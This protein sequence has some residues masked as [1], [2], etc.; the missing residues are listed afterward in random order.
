MATDARLDREREFHDRAFSE[1][2]R[3]TVRRF[4][5]VTDSLRAWYDATLAHEAQDG[6]VLEYGCG[7]GSASYHLARQGA[8]VTGIDI[9]PV[10]IEM[11]REQGERDGLSANLDFRVMD[12]ERLDLPD[13][14]FDVVCGTGIL[15]HLDLDAAY[16]EV[17]RVLRPGG[18]AV[19]VEPLGHNPAINLYRSRTPGLRTVD[20]HPLLMADLDRC[21]DFFGAVDTRF[22][23]LTS[24][25]AFP[26]RRRARFEDVVRGLDRLDQVLFSTLPAARRNAWM[27]GMVLRAP[28]PR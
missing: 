26:L 20:E 2:T 5:S 3:A 22:F 27:V 11:A 12:A 28:R 17:A 16:G 23:A 7:P 1:S 6:T 24:L 21:G 18:V 13:A 4:Y 10:A 9:S 19:F 8:H 15:H 14:S 25:A